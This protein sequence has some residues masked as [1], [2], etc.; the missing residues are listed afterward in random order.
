MWCEVPWGAA[1]LE[2]VA[3]LACWRAESSGGDVTRLG[4]KL[5]TGG[6]TP[7]AAVP[8]D[9]LAAFLR[10]C[11]SSDVPFKLTA[12]LHH[13]VRGPDPVTGGTTHGV[14]NVVAAVDALLRGADDSAIS[15]LLSVTEP[16][17][18]VPAVTA[19]PDDRREAVR[20]CW[21]SFGCCGVTDPLRELAALAMLP[22]DGL[23]APMAT[24]ATAPLTE[25]VP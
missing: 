10:A 20:R 14:L 11:V 3:T 12:G 22:S 24:T 13:A 17:G 6:T 23:V 18:L 8:V 19:I 16:A 1:G 7:E 2:S 15:D 9:A 4:A 5:R 25:E 21:A